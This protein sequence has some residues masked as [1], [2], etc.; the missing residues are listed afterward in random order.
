M[1]ASNAVELLDKK[2]ESIKQM[3]EKDRLELATA[4]EFM[5]LAIVQ[6]AAYISQRAPRYPMRQYLED[7]RRS[8]RKKTSLLNNE[9]GQLR[10]DWEAKNS[11][12]TTW[13]I[14]FEHVQRSWP[15][16]ADLLSLMSFFDRQGIPETL[17]RHRAQSNGGCGSRRQFDQDKESENG[18]ENSENSLSDVSEDDGFED[19]VQVLRNY[20]FISCDTDGTFEMHALVQ[21]AM[22]KWLE[23][24]KQLSTTAL[25]VRKKIFGQEYKETLESMAMVGLA[26]SLGGRW[27]EAKELQIQTTEIM[28]RVLGEEHPETLYSIG[29]LA[30]IY[31]NQG[32]W[33]EAEELEVHVLETTIKVLGE[34]HPDT[35][36]SIN[37]LAVIYQHQ[38]RWK[39]AEE[40]EVHVMKIKKRV[41]GEEHPDKLI[42]MHNLAFTWKAQGQ[43]TMAIVLIREC[44]HLKIRVLGDKH[45][46]TLSSS[47]AYFRWQIREPTIIPLQQVT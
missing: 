38:G 23:A 36:I 26:Y 13:Q 27:E 46:S 7:F 28:K 25:E 6:A 4:L 45:P 3:H 16:A 15:S 10:R 47:R 43:N 40:L 32:H 17:V 12:I 19:D 42:S 37:N 14:S 34:Q 29:N 5:P 24:K 35:L 20:S 22:R 1:D 39:E 41:L 21:L 33:K 2:L 11:I 8:D 18:E 44:I 31:K 30:V 9:G